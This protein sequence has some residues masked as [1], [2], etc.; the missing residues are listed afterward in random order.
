MNFS[1]SIKLT[2]CTLL[3]LLM[4]N[5]DCLAQQDENGQVDVAFLRS[6][7]SAKGN[8][9]MF[10]SAELLYQDTSLYN[11]TAYFIVQKSVFSTDKKV[12]KV[13]KDIEVQPYTTLRQLKSI[14][15]DNELTEIG[16]LLDLKTQEEI[17][18]K[19][20]EEKNPV[21]YPFLYADIRT[22]TALGH[23]WLDE[24]VEKGKMYSYIVYRV[25]KSGKKEK[26]GGAVQMAKNTNA[27]LLQYHT[28]NTE[29][30]TSDSAVSFSWEMKRT[31]T[32]F[33]KPAVTDS[34]YL[35]GYNDE[36]FVHYTDIFQR[37][38]VMKNGVLQSSQLILSNIDD[39]ANNRIVSSIIRTNPEDEIMSW[40]VPEDIFGNQGRSSDTIF[41][42]AVSYQNAPLLLKLKAKDVLDGVRLSW[43]QLPNKPYIKGVKIQRYNSDNLMEEVAVL[44]TLDTAFTDYKV[45]IGHIYRYEASVLFAESVGFEQKIPAQATGQYTE[46]SKPMPPANLRAVQEGVNIR[47]D[48]DSLKVNSLYGYYIYRGYD[49]TEPTLLGGPVKETFFVDT[50]AELSGKSVYTYHVITENLR[51]DVSLPGEPVYIKPGRA[52]QVFPPSA[53][54]TYY[55]NG[56]VNL[57]WDDARK[58]DSYIIGYQVQRK[59]AGAQSFENLGQVTVHPEWVDSDVTPGLAYEYR[60]AS[61]GS[62]GEVSNYSAATLFEVLVEKD[63]TRINLTVRNTHEGV[64]LSWSGIQRANQD[65]YVIYRRKSSEKE[66]SELTTVAVGTTSFTDKT[67]VPG[68]NYIYAVALKFKN[69]TGA[70][71]DAKSISYKSTPKPEILK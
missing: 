49:G 20:Q 26:W 55:A 10:N 54:Q 32:V 22:Q 44:P 33:V 39:S 15:N 48:W 35:T 69:E 19:I 42:Y 14:F 67:V 7:S 18:Q 41:A 37:V 53:I 4:F 21:N 60:V 17:I 24:N 64:A 27:G 71:S 70:K 63:F 56:R 68:E 31:D 13:G 52:V 5:D 51:Q 45:Q 47:L 30:Y 66:F 12:K 28:A 25:D 6:A 23:I 43:P 2:A 3:L 16:T 11:S 1:A 59:T 58:M 29:L 61:V 38:Y 40:V 65:A 50:S 57:K 34:I 9:V 36:F 8:Y 46:F 62:G